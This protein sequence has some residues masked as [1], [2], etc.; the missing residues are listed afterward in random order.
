MS[1]RVFRLPEFDESVLHSA[2]EKLQM[3][4]HHVGEAA[5]KYSNGRTAHTIVG[6]AERK[7]KSQHEYSYRVQDPSQKYRGERK[8]EGKI[9]GRWGHNIFLNFTS[10]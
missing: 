3:K 8:A 6:K 5:Q 1:I 4:N 2:D 7:R 10:D 9:L